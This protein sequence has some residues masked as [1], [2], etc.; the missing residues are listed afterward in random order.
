V[1][2]VESDGKEIQEVG[3][4]GQRKGRVGMKYE[5]RRKFVLC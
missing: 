3:N 4:M 2:W 5:D 1:L